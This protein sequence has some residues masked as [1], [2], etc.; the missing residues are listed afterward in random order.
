MIGG[1]ELFHRCCFGDHS[2][3]GVSVGVL[4]TDVAESCVSRGMLLS[5]DGAN[6]A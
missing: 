4:L 6:V 3:E 2:G 1:V 5:S